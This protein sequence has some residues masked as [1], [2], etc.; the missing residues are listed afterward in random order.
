MHKRKYVESQSTRLKP[1]SERS[2]ASIKIICGKA[3]AGASIEISLLMR[4]LPV[5]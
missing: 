4:A 2:F 1:D 3:T 5:L